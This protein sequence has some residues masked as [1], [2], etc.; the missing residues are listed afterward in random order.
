MPYYVNH[1]LRGTKKRISTEGYT[2]RLCSGLGVLLHVLRTDVA[3]VAAEMGIS[4]EEA[5]REVQ[6]REVRQ[7]CGSRGSS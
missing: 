7:A 1:M 5:G 4:V 3:A 2:G 6:Y